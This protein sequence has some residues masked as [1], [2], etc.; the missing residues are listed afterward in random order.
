M[1]A[2]ERELTIAVDAGWDQAGSACRAALSELGWIVSSDRGAL[3]EACEN[4]IGLGCRTTPSTLKIEL[5]AAA[6]DETVVKLSGSAP[7]I[8]RSPARRL[9]RQLAALARRLNA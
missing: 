5:V 6:R 9:G 3:V 2:A 8:G 1:F 7:G 4:P